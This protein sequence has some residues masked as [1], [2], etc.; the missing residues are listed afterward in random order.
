MGN[1]WEWTDGIGEKKMQIL[2]VPVFSQ[3]QKLH[4]FRRFLSFFHFFPFKKAGTLRIGIPPDW[5]AKVKAN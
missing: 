4:L 3:S 5:K 1:G 2:A